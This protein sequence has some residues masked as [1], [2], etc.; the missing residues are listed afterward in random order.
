MAAKQ[1][2]TD[3]ETRR[4]WHLF[5]DPT[6]FGTP[7]PLPDAGAP[8]ASSDGGV[9]TDAGVIGDDGGMTSADAGAPDAAVAADASVGTDAGAAADAASAMDAGA[10]ADASGAGDAGSVAD[11]GGAGGGSG[12]GGGDAGGR[13]APRDGCDCQVSGGPSPGSLT[14]C[15]ALALLAIG[16]PGRRRRRRGGARWP[17]ALLA[18][19]GCLAAAPSAQ[20]AYGF[21][22]SIT[23]DRTR[24][25]NTGAPTTLA[26]YPLLIS[27]TNNN[28]RTFPSGNVRNANG[29]DIAFTGADTT[30]CGGPAT[31][32]FNYEIERYNGATGEVI[33]WVNIPALRTVSATSDTV[34]FIQ[35]GDAAISA[36][37][38][39]MNGTWETNFRG[40]WHLNQ[41]PAGAAPQMTDSTST[42]AHATANNGP[43]ATTTA[44]VGAGVTLD[45][46]NDYSDF[47]TNAAFN[48]TASDTFTYSGLVRDVGRKRAHHV[49]AQ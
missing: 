14:V 3:L 5:G 47:T 43:T 49:V 18:L 30:T 27:V 8:D 35:Y 10:A 40:V 2:I 6:L 11:V 13:P 12:A 29:Y 31:C 28:L 1:S 23:I 20:A 15:G 45:G 9:A 48:W 37:T 26:N 33:A 46:T 17:F 19:V 16:R 41:S 25:G 39:N 21:R 38:Q 36:P 42:A 24:I 4:T 7:R 44:R 32:T 22:R 34:I